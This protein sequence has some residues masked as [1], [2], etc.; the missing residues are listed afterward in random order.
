M[1]RT[2]AYLTSPTPEPCFLAGRPNRVCPADLGGPPPHE[3]A[4]DYLLRGSLC[5]AV[6]SS[7]RRSSFYPF[8]IG[9][10]LD[11]AVSHG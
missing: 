6:F 7:S 3:R 10:F 9:A 5:G 2:R 4:R 11:S 1:E 8:R